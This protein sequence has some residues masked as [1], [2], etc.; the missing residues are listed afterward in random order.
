MS[1]GMTIALS[2]ANCFR[3]H[4]PYSGKL[5]TLPIMSKMMIAV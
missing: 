2:K 4:F 5:G 3:Q 1:E